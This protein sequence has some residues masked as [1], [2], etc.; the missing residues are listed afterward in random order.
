MR[1]SLLINTLRI[2]R[3]QRL[4]VIAACQTPR[5]LHSTSNT[6][7]TLEPQPIA[8]IKPSQPIHNA[9]SNLNNPSTTL[10][11]PSQILQ[12]IKLKTLTSLHPAA[13]FDTVWPLVSASPPVMSASEMTSIMNQMVSSI[14]PSTNPSNSNISKQ[15]IKL[16]GQIKRLGFMPPPD[17][18]T[19]LVIGASYSHDQVMKLLAF[20]S[21]HPENGSDEF[22]RAVLSSLLE[23]RVHTPQHL[24]QK[25][26]RPMWVAM[27]DLGIHPAIETCILCVK[28]FARSGDSSGLNDIY[29]YIK[30]R[31][32][33]DERTWNALVEGYANMGHTLT[34][35]N[36]ISHMKSQDITLS[37]STLGSVMEAYSKA[38]NYNQVINL[39]PYIPPESYSKAVVK[40]LANA[41]AQ[42]GRQED[43]TKLLEQVTI[44]ISQAHTSLNHRVLEYFVAAYSDLGNAELAMSVFNTYVSPVSGLLRDGTSY[45]IVPDRWLLA[46]LCNVLGKAHAEDLIKCI[47]RDYVMTRDNMRGYILSGVAFDQAFS[48]CLEQVRLGWM[49]T[50][51]GDE[52]D[53]ANNIMQLE[54]LLQKVSD[55][56]EWNVLMA[57]LRPESG[58]KGVVVRPKYK[59][60]VVKE[61]TLG[62]LDVGSGL[63]NHGRVRSQKIQNQTRRRDKEL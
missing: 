34:A 47:F 3:S 27:K 21:L 33:K 63:D 15:L 16:F 60:A 39:H 36:M 28:A 25:V 45:K 32:V 26:T 31:K 57:E 17:A 52:T 38:E 9:T 51:A 2:V 43:V 30:E 54:E 18:Y 10:Q 12:A 58:R 46:K 37:R 23:G 41:Y 4:V 1:A 20:V 24:V 8:H 56:G 5:N 48:P 22:Y 40:C 59:Q 7:E 49:Q 13:I 29:Q 6:P 44:L 62:E 55:R 35:E 61:T 14:N 42:S 19:A 50:L 53:Q 11:S